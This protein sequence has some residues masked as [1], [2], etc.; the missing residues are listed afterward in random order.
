MKLSGVLHAAAFV[1]VPLTTVVACVT[2]SDD[3]VSIGDDCA[4][5][6]CPPDSGS[7]IAPAEAGGDA[8]VP[9]S[10]SLLMCKGTECPAPYTTCSNGPSFLCG[11]NLLTDSQNCGA[12]GHSCEGYDTVN[13]AARCVNGACAFECI[14]VAPRGHDPLIFRDCNNLLDD[15][16]EVNVYADAQNCGACGNA[17]PAGSHCFAGKCGCGPGK[18]DCDGACVD[19]SQDDGNCGACGKFCDT[20]PVDACDPPPPNS[21]YGCGGGAC[22]QLKCVSGSADCNYDL[23]SSCASDGCESDVSSDPANCGGCGV[24]CGTGQVCIS[25][26]NGPHCADTCAMAGLT[27]CAD[28]CYDLVTDPQSCGACGNVCPSPGQ[29]Q[30]SSCTKGFCKLDCLPGFDDCNGD[31]SD[32]CEVDLSSHPAN[33]GA[34]GNACDF[35]AGQPCI[36]GKCLMVACDAGPTK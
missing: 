25:D 5:G 1:L 33:C 11:T 21:F 31:P 3:K 6:F 20:L 8:D 15:G 22:G 7:F 30:T 4:N 19:L 36:E 23:N 27:Q 16:C 29:H 26:Q 12:C 10:E 34:C 17:C 32:G 24:K 2:G 13:M 9:D 28:G 35:A 14:S 18:T